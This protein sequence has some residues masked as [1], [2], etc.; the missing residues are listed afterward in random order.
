MLNRDM[1]EIE[2]KYKKNVVKAGLIGLAVGDALGVPVEFQSRK[3]LDNEPVT[4]MRSYG[5]HD[6][7]AGT[8]SDDSSLTFCLAE[9]I[10]ETGISYQ[11]QANRFI[12]WLLRVEWTPYGEVFDV[13]NA[14]SE[15]IFRLDAGVK[16][17]EA[18]PDSESNCGNGS[19]MRI[20]P[21]AI[22]FAYAKPAERIEEAMR[23]SRL[24]HGHIRCQLACAFF[25]E[26][27][28]ELIKG[29]GISVS[30]AIGQSRMNS[31]I[32]K[33]HPYEYD[34]FRAVF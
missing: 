1:T 28:S 14:T 24:T 17:T 22:Y 2:H 15:A 11:D 16:P 31:L 7:P 27:A 8:W 9:S 20:L 19:L 26:V 3:I 29:N 4:R 13:G 25:I 6:Q 33:E 34:A 18:G 5:T 32:E 21:I 12:G 23:C 30:I 10:C